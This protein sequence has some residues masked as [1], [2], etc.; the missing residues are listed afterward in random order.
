MLDWS[1]G[2]D[3]VAPFRDNEVSGYDT[4]TQTLARAHGRTLA[5]AEA[6][7]AFI[8]K[9]CNAHDALVHALALVIESYEAGD[10]AMATKQVIDHVR[11]ILATQRVTP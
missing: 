11:S 4:Q 3:C 10:G 1:S 9:A 7:A 6:N 8:V 2:I 5:E